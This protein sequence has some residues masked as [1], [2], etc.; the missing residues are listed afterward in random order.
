MDENP[1]PKGVPLRLDRDARSADS[2]LPAYVA[3]PEDAPVYHGFRLLEQSRTDDGRCS[4]RI[5]EPGSPK[6]AIA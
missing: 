5:S 2:S 4:G 6:E 1:K 3:R